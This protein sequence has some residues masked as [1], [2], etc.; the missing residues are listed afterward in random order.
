MRILLE[1]ITAA[2]LAA[3][4]V[5]TLPAAADDCPESDPACHLTPLQSHQVNPFPATSPADLSPLADSSSLN[6]TNFTSRFSLGSGSSSPVG[7]DPVF[8]E[9][10][11]RIDG[12][13]RGP[14]RSIRRPLIHVH[15][16]VVLEPNEPAG[17][18][19]PEVV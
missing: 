5:L 6:V 12:L 3:V 18:E 16:D 13:Q 9:L 14:L 4:S 8:A 7:D 1:L 19:G 17:S 11:A 15:R 10:T 2:L